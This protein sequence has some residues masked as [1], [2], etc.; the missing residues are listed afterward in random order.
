MSKRAKRLTLAA[1]AALLLIVAVWAVGC[2]TVIVPP[3]EPP[4]PAVVFVVDYGRHASLLLPDAA[5]LSMIEY[6]YGDWG[7]FAL[8]RSTAL[9]IFPT[10]LWPTQGAL[11]RWR[12]DI[13]VTGQ[14]VRRHIACED[15]LELTVD[16]RLVE[17]LRK[18]LDAR[19]RKHIDTLHHQ[20]LYRLDFVHDDSKYHALYNCNHVLAKWLEEL[21]CDVRGWAMFADFVVREPAAQ[22]QQ[23]TQ[24]HG[25]V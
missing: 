8:D 9:D 20:Q 3:A 16:S 17:E 15:V 12:W 22:T 11:G 23:A 19:F 7:W 1:M 14:S 6:A 4:D 2:R 24:E 25:P 18:R 5:R 10:L 13:Q 21:G